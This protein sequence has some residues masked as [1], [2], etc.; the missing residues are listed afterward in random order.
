[1]HA[2]HTRS[3]A[4]P[5]ADACAARRAGDI[6]AS[7]RTHDPLVLLRGDACAVLRDEERDAFGLVNEREHHGRGPVLCG[8]LD[9]IEQGASKKLAVTDEVH[10][11]RRVQ[12]IDRHRQRRR[13]RV[14]GRPGK[15]VLVERARRKA[16]LVWV[17]ARDL[18]AGCLQRF[19]DQRVEVAEIGLEFGDA[20]LHLAAVVRRRRQQGERDADTGERG[21][22]LVRHVREHLALRR[23][24]TLD[25]P[26]VDTSFICRG[27]ERD[28]TAAWRRVSTARHR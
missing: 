4:Q 16:G 24:L 23:H 11:R 15:H 25:P 27:G 7:E 21:A 18:E 3:E 1:M 6:A 17:Q 14:G 19:L 8:V 13:Q 12:R 22:Q 10:A 2:R 5:Q 26:G 20:L 9:E 28:R